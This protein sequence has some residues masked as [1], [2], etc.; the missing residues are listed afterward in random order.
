[1]AYADTACA[2]SV[3]GQEND[4][5]LV[6]HCKQNN[7]PYRLVSDREQFRF[8]PGKR[9]WS[10]QALLLSVVSGKVA[11]VIRFSIVPPE[12]PFLIS[13]FVFKRLGVILDLDDNELVLKR[14]GIDQARA[15]EPLYDLMSGHVVVE[16]VPEGKAPPQ[17]SEETLDLVSSGHEF[18]VNDPKLKKKTEQL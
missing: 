13:K 1:M 9:I 14:F 7:W 11:I 17:I 3:T 2:R 10:S 15:V 5:S 4:D 16:L 8:G 6:A 18:M 12:V